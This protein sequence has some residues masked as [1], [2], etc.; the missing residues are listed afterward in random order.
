M[1]KVKFQCFIASVSNLRVT[2]NVMSGVQ[3]VLQTSLLI[4]VCAQRGGPKLN[5]ASVCNSIVN[6]QAKDHFLE[7]AT[8]PDVH[9]MSLHMRAFTSHFVLQG[10]KRGFKA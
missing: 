10:K 1:D 3:T 9:L 7:F 6:T 5:T 4:L 2:S 8:T